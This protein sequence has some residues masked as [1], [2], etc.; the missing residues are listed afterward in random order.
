MVLLLICIGLL[1]DDKFV[2]VGLANWLLLPLPVFGFE[3][4]DDDVVVGVVEIAGLFN[5]SFNALTNTLWL[6]DI[7]FV[8]CKRNALNECNDT[9]A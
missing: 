3:P 8:C 1:F 7:E 6:S 4:C 9:C 5:T 2:V